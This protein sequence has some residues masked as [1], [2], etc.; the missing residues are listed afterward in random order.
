VTGRNPWPPRT[1]WAALV[2]TLRDAQ[3]ASRVPEDNRDHGPEDT[4]DD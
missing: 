4:D 1:T 3:D 2:A